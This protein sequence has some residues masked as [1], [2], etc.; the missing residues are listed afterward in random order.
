MRFRLRTLLIVLALGLLLLA[1][2]WFYPFAV[3]LAVLLAAGLYVA[4]GLL[5]IAFCIAVVLYFTISELVEKW[6]GPR[7]AER[8]RQFAIW[9]AHY[10]VPRD[11]QKHHLT[12]I[13]QES[14]GSSP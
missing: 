14:R 1:A 7:R 12:R 10:R 5:Y 11:R 2:L 6:E 4:V 13:E 3:M 8:C 9:A